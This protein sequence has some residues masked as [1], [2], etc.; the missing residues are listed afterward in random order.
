[1]KNQKKPRSCFES[2]AFFVAISGELIYDPASHECQ[3][4]HSRESGNLTKG[5]DAGSSPA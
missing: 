4:C 1:M 2:G 3:R 5:L